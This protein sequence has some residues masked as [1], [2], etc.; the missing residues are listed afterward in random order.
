MAIR[1]KTSAKKAAWLAFGLVALAAVSS[2][3]QETA[4]ESIETESSNSVILETESVNQVPLDDT[5]N[6][7]AQPAHDHAT[8]ASRA[9]KQAMHT[10]STMTAHPPVHT[11]DSSS[12]IGNSKSVLSS[13]LPNLQGRGP[14]GSAIRIIGRIQ[15]QFSADDSVKEPKK[16]DDEVDR[17]AIK[18]LDLLQHSAEL[19][20][21]DALYTLG[22]ISLFPPT[23]QFVPD[24]RVAFDSFKAHAFITGNASSQAYLAFFYA[25]GYHDV[26]QVDQARAQLHY[27]F[28]ANGG[29]KGAQMALGY[30]Y[31]SG[32][33]T[34]EN[35]QR[36]MDWYEQAAELAMAKFLSGPPGGR[37]LPQTPTRLS[38][39]VGGIYGP[40]A[41]VA[42][43]GH[44]AQRPAIKAGISRASG[45]TW[46][47]I[48]DYYLFNADRGETD[49]AY[50]LG[51][52]YYQGS[53]YASPGGIA[54][55]SEG[56]GA[57]PRDFSRAKHYF[58]QI[59]RQVWPRDP[60][61]PLHHQPPPR[62]SKE[63][64][65]PVGY[66]ASSAGYLGRMYL[67]GEGVKADP[68]I[69]KMWFERGEVYGERECHNGLGIINRD[70]L[71]PG[72]KADRKKAIFH[73][74]AAANQELAEAQ[75]NLA[76]LNFDFGDLNIA[77]TQFDA[78][79]R[80]GSPFEAYY[81]LGRVYSSQA[82]ASNVPANMASSSCAMAVSFYKLVSERG[83]WDDDL[84]REAEV[85][86]ASGTPQNKDTAILKWW[87]AAERGSEIAQNNLA[88]VLDQDRSMLRLTRFSPITPS[89]DTARLALT[90]WIRAAGQRNI[91]A[92][93]KVADYYYH[94]LGIPEES[95]LSRYEKAARYYQS[96]ADTQL[97][98]LAMWN[99]GWMYENGIGVP[100][101]FHL[102]KRHYDAA[103]DANSE[104]YLPVFLSLTKLYLRS[105]WHT[106]M[107]GQ[108]GLSLWTLDEE[109]LSTSTNDLREIESSQSDASSDSGAEDRV[110]YDDEEGPWYL[111]KAR[112]EFHRRRTG[113]ANARRVD[114]DEDPISWA[115]D[116]RNAEQDRD[117]DL[118]PED[119]FDAALR[120]GRRGEGDVD[121]FSETMLLVVLCL[122]VS[123]LIWVRTRIVRRM[124][125]D[126]QNQQRQQQER[127]ANG[128]FPLP[129]DPAR[130]EWAVL[131]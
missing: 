44:N 86:W 34:L 42:S 129:G 60:P 111:G 104:A 4:P 22:K 50:R 98:A 36:A 32:I 69:A 12:Y 43:T 53:I 63:D 127:P 118:G 61:N 96:A 81:Y 17:K 28:A 8:E 20:N 99:L 115:R 116:R 37:T 52:I 73:F 64:N 123:V 31:W 74:Q 79:I 120:G 59:A 93:V 23:S 5:Q 89:N 101:D 117:N 108:D 100:Q 83:V 48:L 19:G 102:A 14:I 27:T 97:S 87:I 16:K 77:S 119:Y 85:A 3:A 58:E 105:I 76:K 38:D 128:V 90:Q 121:E 35:C 24:P 39:L 107:G 56:V 125:R 30:R 15:Q 82:T 47:D 55:G 114:D 51:K 65:L 54:S 57:V 66:A 122:T 71:I 109:E 75:V 126:Q 103:L 49:F 46:E 112:D 1:R 11:Y 40:G 2:Y 131:R 9:Y 29:D 7:V 25:T 78:A 10:L 33:G 62:A 94:G 88:Y 68:A 6:S 91:D 110:F 13:V 26:V 130:D 124:R 67:R 113:Q 21:T 106:L 72:I 70:G 18:V 92:L 95:E 84:L 41:S 80:L 45:E